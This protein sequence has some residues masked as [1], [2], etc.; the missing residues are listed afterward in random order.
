MEKQNSIFA[1]SVENWKSK[2]IWEQVLDLGE[3]C[4]WNVQKVPNIVFELQNMTTWIEKRKSINKKSFVFF[5]LI[6]ESMWFVHRRS[7]L[8]VVQNQTFSYNWRKQ[9][10]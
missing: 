4:R 5:F 1:V 6:A 10:A 9:T 2:T 8:W 7:E 3:Y